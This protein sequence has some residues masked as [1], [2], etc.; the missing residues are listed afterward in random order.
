MYQCL[1]CGLLLHVIFKRI[2]VLWYLNLRRCLI[3]GGE[4]GIF[5]TNYT[6]F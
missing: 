2:H 5:G 3:L 1:W 4:V 6:F